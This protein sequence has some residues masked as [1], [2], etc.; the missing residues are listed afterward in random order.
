M[1]PT[2]SDPSTSETPFQI[3]DGKT[4]RTVWLDGDGNGDPSPTLFE[5]IRY[6]HD[7]HPTWKIYCGDAPKR[8]NGIL[9]EPPRFCYLD[10]AAAHRIANWDGYSKPYK[11]RCWRFDFG[12]KGELRP[13]RPNR[14]RPAYVESGEV[15]W[16]EMGKKGAGG[17]GGGGGRKRY[18]FCG[19]ERRE[20]LETLRWMNE[21]GLLEHRSVPKPSRVPGPGTRVIEMP[22]EA[23]PMPVEASQEMRDGLARSVMEEGVDGRPAKRLRPSDLFCSLDV[24]RSRN[25]ELAYYREL[26]KHLYALSKKAAESLD[27]VANIDAT[28]THLNHELFQMKQDQK[29]FRKALGEL[30]SMMKNGM[31]ELWSQVESEVD[32][33]VAGGAADGTE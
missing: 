11:G 22:G 16:E 21:H 17:G 26:S 31:G 2:P 13:H 23:V 3:H 5:R 29:Q 33:E 12:S 20:D 28:V 7:G 30:E 15:G 9:I 1:D 27:R 24:G 25:A 4:L 8:E 14:G 32:G 18:M 6:T 19:S 10:D